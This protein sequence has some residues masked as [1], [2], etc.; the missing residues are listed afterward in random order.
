MSD[1]TFHDNPTTPADSPSSAA[2][3]AANG[4]SGPNPSTRP[5]LDTSPV[6]VEKL[7][8][9]LFYRPERISQIR[10]E[11]ERSSAADDEADALYTRRLREV[12]NLA[13][14][15][16]LVADSASVSEHDDGAQTQLHALTVALGH[17]RRDALGDGVAEDDVLA[18]ELAGIEGVPW[19]VGPS[20]RWLGRID[21]LSTQAQFFS[22]QA[23]ENG[24][25]AM[26]LKMQ[27]I[28]QNT[29]ILGLEY[30]VATSRALLRELLGENAIEIAQQ[31][32]GT[33]ATVAD[34]GEP[35]PS[36]AGEAGGDI[37]EA[38]GAALPVTEG[39]Q[40]V[41]E[42]AQRS[43]DPSATAGREPEL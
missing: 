3:S 1:N 11:T 23:F 43:E 9:G 21:E 8:L 10:A 42:S 31:I 29:R 15:T 37:G 35:V 33:T 40:W 38:I 25:L 18:A 41:P 12:Q 17:A 26:Q 20:H 16:T 2:D 14:A 36:Q 24:Q 27:V 6:Q 30:Q 22:R 39:G 32:V 28:E 7:A 4:E 19:A 13:A 34:P 5:E